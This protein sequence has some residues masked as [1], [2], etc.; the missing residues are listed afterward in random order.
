MP[1]ETPTMSDKTPSIVVD[2]LEFQWDLVAGGFS[3]GGIPAVALFRDSSLVSLLQGFVSMVGP[4]RFALALRAEGQRGIE[5]DWAI[6]TSEPSFEAGFRKL[7][8]YAATNGWGRWECVDVDRE[9]KQA[10]FRVHD[11]WEGLAQRSNK[12]NWGSGLIAGKF[13]GL[14]ARLFG[15]NCWSR[16]TMFIADDDPY[17]EIVVEASERDIAKELAELAQSDQATNMDLT[18]ALSELRSTAEA[19]A[20][21]LGER[22]RSVADMQEKLDIIARQQ[23][24]IQALSTP[25]IQVW[26]GVLAVPVVGAVDGERTSRMME[27]LLETII[28][29][30][31]RYA[32]IDVT[33]VETVDT[34]T[35][36]NFVRLIRGVQL[37]GAQG[38]ISGIGPLVAQ[39]IVDLGVDLSGIP[40]FSNLKEALH[41]CIGG[42]VARSRRGGSQ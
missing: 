35:A 38:I 39:T 33:G 4:Q 14:G 2:G 15:T 9:A 17:D 10:V 31:S 37:L 28:H 22:D 16:Q 11:S 12:V 5:D 24:A 25:I 19:H 30:K 34:H 13:T 20:R 26:D 3:I 6:I 29:S 8:P 23:A 42:T 1:P 41:A 36:D 27:K 40:T 32:I 18:R 21:A 7:A